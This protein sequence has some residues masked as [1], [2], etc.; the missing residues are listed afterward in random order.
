MPP[1]ASHLS[2]PSR[3]P[4]ASELP[5]R[6]EV[7][8]RGDEAPLPRSR[9][10]A[11]ESNRLGVEALVKAR[12]ERPEGIAFRA[13][14][15]VRL[16]GGRILLEFLPAKEPELLEIVPHHFVACYLYP[17]VTSATN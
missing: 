3:N 16:D 6:E 11:T 15:Y 14:Q 10:P 13:I 5:P 12:A 1:T 4:A 2:D 7:T 8:I 17:G 9:D